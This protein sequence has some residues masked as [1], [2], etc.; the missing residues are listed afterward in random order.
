[1]RKTYMAALALAVTTAAFALMDTAPAKAAIYYPWCARYSGSIGGGSNCYFQTRAQCGAAISGVGG[2]CE[3]K[4]FYYAYGAEQDPGYVKP[5]K[6][7]R[8]RHYY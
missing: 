1:M 5:S 8:A 3:P 7:K 6:R 2:V 4:G